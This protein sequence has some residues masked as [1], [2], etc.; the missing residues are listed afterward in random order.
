MGKDVYNTTGVDQ[1]RWGKA[2]RGGSV[3]YFVNVQNDAAFAEA[4]RLR[5]TA[6]TTRFAVRYFDPAGQDITRGIKAGTYETPVLAPGAKFKVKVVV[7]VR[8]TAPIGS[9]LTGSLA[10]TSTTHP[11]IKDKVKFVT[12]CV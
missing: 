9:S 4:L 5:G 10:A 6:S 2:P 8:A 3:T 11:T 12:R 7:T 1:T